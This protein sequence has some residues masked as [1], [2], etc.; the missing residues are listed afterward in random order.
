MTE[1]LDELQEGMDVLFPEYE[2]RVQELFERMLQG[3]ILSCLTELMRQTIAKLSADAVGLKNL[4]IWLILLGIASALLS[5]VVEL[6]D[7]HQVADLGFYFVYLS[8]IAVLLRCF[9]DSAETAGQAL[10]NIVL[11]GRLLVPVYLIAVGAATGSISAAAYYQLFLILIYG[12]EKLLLGVGLPL[13]YAFCMLNV[14]NGIWP[15]EK[16]SLFIDFVKKCIDWLIKGAIG[17]VT[18]VSVFQSLLNP[19]LDAFRAGGMQKAM[20]AIPGMGN[21]AEGVLELAVGSAVVIKNSVGVVLLCGLLLLC[22]N[23]LLKILLTALV[24]KLSAALMG[25]VSDKRI[26]LAA[27]RAGDAALCLLRTTA[28][29]FFLFFISL[30]VS[31]LAT[32]RG[33]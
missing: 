26:T 4:F 8:M 6:F 21:A 14:I 16:L 5:H 13:C 27:N 19:V 9:L 7:A 18:G 25:M 32:N 29:G 24:I 22:V 28:T 2:I 17:I 12:V 11:F 10:E 3:D 15:E 20:T 23:P 33:F 31:T 30:A 1:Y